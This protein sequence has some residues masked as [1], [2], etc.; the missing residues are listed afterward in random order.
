MPDS[1][2]KKKQKCNTRNHGYLSIILI[3]IRYDDTNYK[4]FY[5]NQEIPPNISWD[6]AVGT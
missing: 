1:E 6:I 2:V 4:N 3:C 5:F